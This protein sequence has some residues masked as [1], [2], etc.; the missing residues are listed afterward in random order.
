MKKI[1]SL[2][3]LAVLG[4]TL[5][6]IISFSVGWWIIGLALIAG[7]G[8]ILYRIS[9]PS[10]GITQLDFLKKIPGNKSWWTYGLVAFSTLYYVLLGFGVIKWEWVQFNVLI[11][12]LIIALSA[13]LAGSKDISS[14]L[15]G[16]MKLWTVLSIA[17]I[18][19]L[20]LAT[21][22]APGLI[23]SLDY[24]NSSVPPP[25]EQSAGQQEQVVSPSPPPTSEAPIARERI[26]Q[27][28]GKVIVL[29]KSKTIN[30]PPGQK[31]IC[32]SW[33][34]YNTNGD[35]VNQ[36]LTIGGVQFST[37]GSNCFPVEMEGEVE[38]K[39][40]NPPQTEVDTY[41]IIRAKGGQ[42]EYPFIKLPK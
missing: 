7:G 36:Q 29:T 28:P 6:T 38:V 22:F 9:G 40:L 23:Q 18:I 15:Q 41:K 10:V 37:Q 24:S 19:A 35:R 8:F 32:F 4:Y 31:D 30:L 5:I 26:A 17:G 33:L 2:I 34:G 42:G 25:T 27:I 12:L 11:M 1:N 20:M 21:R 39:F 14:S 3:L 13:V 16:V